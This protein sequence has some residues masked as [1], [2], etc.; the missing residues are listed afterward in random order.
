MLLAL[1]VTLL[2]LGVGYLVLDGRV[3]R[4]E[5]ALSAAPRP[6]YI[7]QECGRRVE[8]SSTV[9]PIRLTLLCPDDYHRR[10]GALPPAPTPEMERRSRRRRHG[11]GP[12]PPMMVLPR[13]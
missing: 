2:A 4:Q 8:Y 11:P 10:F 6:A 3:R 9:R 5:A 12:R 1:G 13:R 7:C